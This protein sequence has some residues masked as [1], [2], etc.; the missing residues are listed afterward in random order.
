MFRYGNVLDELGAMGIGSEWLFQSDQ[1][2]I[3]LDKTQCVVT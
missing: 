2:A 1:L 3:N